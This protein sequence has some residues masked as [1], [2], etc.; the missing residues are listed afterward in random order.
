METKKISIGYCPTMEPYAIK[1]A[2][3]LTD[4]NIENLGGA[5]NALHFLQSGQIDAVLI[6]RKAKQR[7]INKSIYEKILKKGITLINSTRRFINEEDLP[8]IQIH[9]A[10]SKEIVQN[11]TL[12]NNKILYYNTLYEALDSVKNEKDA[13][14]IDWDYWHD[15]FEL[16]IPINTYGKSPQFRTP[17]LYYTPDL[18]NDII[19]RIQEVIQ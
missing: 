3:V 2:K 8:A 9:T 12:A 5:A 15:D 11:T 18:S 19:S 6:G 17:I 14:L 7:E 10:L 1:L 4:F 13:L 16:L